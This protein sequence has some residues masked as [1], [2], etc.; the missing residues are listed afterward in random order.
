[1]RFDL[2][3]L[4]ATKALV[5]LLGFHLF[6]LLTPLHYLKRRY[7]HKETHMVDLHPWTHVSKHLGL[8]G[9]VI[10]ADQT[11]HQGEGLGHG[12]PYLRRLLNC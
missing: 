2:V 8:E 12:A 4:E 11:S 9:G 1:M 5:Y 10:L 3:Q 6:H 7:S